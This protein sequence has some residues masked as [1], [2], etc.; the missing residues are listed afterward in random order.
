MPLCAHHPPKKAARDDGSARGLPGCK[1]CAGLQKVTGR[2]LGTRP[3][4]QGSRGNAASVF[5]NVHC[6][7]HD[8]TNADKASN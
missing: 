6:G 5:A 1:G 8:F 7:S 4:T 2:A 3:V